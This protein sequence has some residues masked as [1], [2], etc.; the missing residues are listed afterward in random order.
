MFANKCLTFSLHRI[1]KL[2]KKTFIILCMLFKVGRQSKY[3]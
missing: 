3:I 1:I 2:G